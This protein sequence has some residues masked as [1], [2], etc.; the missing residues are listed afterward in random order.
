MNR[1]LIHILLLLPIVLFVSVSCRK[2]LDVP[3][4][5]LVPVNQMWKSKNDARSAL[6]ATYGLMRAA[7]AN[8]NAYFVYG[9]MR[10]GDFLSTSNADLRA[11]LSNDLNATSSVMEDWKN[12]RRFYAV[13]AQ[14]NLCMT[15]L[16]TVHQNDFRYTE[17][18][19]KL[20][21]AN[22]RFIR[23]LAYFYL[24]RIWGDV[25]LITNLPGNN[26]NE[27]KRED[28]HKVLDF[29]MQ[30]VLEALNDLPWQYNG[31]FPE[32]QGLYWGQ[33]ASFWKGK[34]ATKGSAYS[35]LAHLAA[36]R[37]NYLDAARY[38]K[39]ITD[40]ISLSG[41]DWSYTS[42]LTNPDGGVFKGQSD[43]IIFFLSTYSEYQE[44][45]ATGHIEAWTLALP[46]I[47]RQVPIIYVPNDTIVNVFNETGDERFYIDT[48]GVSH[49]NYFTGFGSPAPVFSKIRLLSVSGENPMQNYESGIVLFRYEE[50]ELL[51]AEALYFLGNSDEAIHWLNAVRSQRGLPDY[52]EGKD[53]L[54]DAI[55]NE[56]RRELMGEGWR[57]YDLIRFNKVTQYSSLTPGDIEGGVLLWPIA[58]DVLDHT[59]GMMQN[60]YWKH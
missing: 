60:D 32:Q 50:I 4:T 26:F 29:A 39:K 58:T 7:L 33:S 11:V 51:Q 48:N 28:Q 30:E 17:D 1:K 49:G 36:W 47:N 56:R 13:I 9:E 42:T 53:E 18:E 20:D 43:D 34:I 59:P 40:N 52:K 21:L 8:N 3:S 24:V 31:S 15:N 27:V 44:S 41:F 12:W 25:P 35:L 38:T 45:S 2:M 55:L 14:A 22:V 37:G 46:Y 23:A 19:L 16:E 54:G 10:A 6:F 5:H 57:W